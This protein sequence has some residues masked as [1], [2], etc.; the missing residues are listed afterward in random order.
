VLR[1]KDALR[2]PLRN[3]AE[4]VWPLLK[5]RPKMKNI[6]IS[7]VLITMMIFN[8]NCHFYANNKHSINGVDLDSSKYKDSI[9]QNYN[10]DIQISLKGDSVYNDDKLQYKDSS[11]YLYVNY[12]VKMIPFKR[13]LRTL[14][15]VYDKINN[16]LLKLTGGCFIKIID[17]YAIVDYGTSSSRSFKIFDIDNVKNVFSD[18]YQILTLKI[19]D[20]SPA[21]I[22]CGFQKVCKHSGTRAA[23]LPG[24]KDAHRSPAL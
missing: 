1:E 9:I 23:T 4:N 7:I 19:I 16:R 22:Q 3:I 14:I 6:L 20:K 12:I 24:D 10:S 8:S 13:D 17:N 21:H 15:L 11:V 2:K 18:Q 5:I